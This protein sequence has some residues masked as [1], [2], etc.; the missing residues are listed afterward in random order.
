[1]ISA[2][3]SA[4][5]SLAMI[6]VLLFQLV[7]INKRLGV[8]VSAFVVSFPVGST[9]WEVPECPV[10][11]FCLLMASGKHP[12]WAMPAP[13]V[14]DSSCC[15][16]MRLSQDLAHFL[17]V[18]AVTMSCAAVAGSLLFAEMT[19]QVGSF[20]GAVV[21]A[22]KIAMLGDGDGI[23]S[24]SFGAGGFGM[25]LSPAEVMSPTRPP[26]ALACRPLHFTL[27]YSLEVMTG[28]LVTFSADLVVFLLLQEVSFALFL[29]LLRP[30]LMIMLMML[31]GIYI[32][33]FSSEDADARESCLSV[34]EDVAGILQDRIYRSS[35]RVRGSGFSD[36]VTGAPLRSCLRTSCLHLM[37]K[38]CCCAVSQTIIEGV[39]KMEERLIARQHELE[40]AGLSSSMMQQFM[41]VSAQGLAVKKAM[42]AFK[43][44]AISKDLTLRAQ[45]VSGFAVPSCES[46]SYRLPCWGPHPGQP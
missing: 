35:V 9:P 14:F 17:V 43:R 2:V 25:D 15:M 46:R 24:G 30:M 37:L 10:N 20:G 1:M 21:W 8:T 19:Q 18:T 12:H 28:R 40:S 7:R 26:I 45:L 33:A 32:D 44:D 3:T 42:K 16:M 39:D 6:F 13:P 38:A 29:W 23:T 4:V 34:A 11:Q 5:S 41:S 22:W 31:S 36:S 27:C